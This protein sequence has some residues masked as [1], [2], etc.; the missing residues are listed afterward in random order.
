MSTSS[1][2]SEPF[3]EERFLEDLQ[4]GSEELGSPY[5]EKAVKEFVKAHDGLMRN[6]AMQ[7]RGSS[8]PGMPIIF[9][10]ILVDSPATATEMAISN[11]WLRPDDPMVVLAKACGTQFKESFEQGE[12]T[13]NTGCHGMLLYLGGLQPLDELL[14][15]PGMPE[16]IKAHRK[17]FVDLGL[18]QCLIAH[19]HYFERLV[20]IYFF[21]QGP[22]SKEALDKVVAMAGVPPPSDAKYRDIIGVLLD[23]PYYLTVVMDFNTGKVVWVEYHMLFP[24]K[25]PPNM[26]IP[27]VGEQMTK[28]WDMPSYEYEVME[29]LSYCFGD[30]RR[31]EVLG[32][33]SYCGG[34]RSLMQQYGIVGA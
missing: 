24:I 4:K 14:A 28:F 8:D 11:G 20:S 21:A 23:S 3:S 31:G 34:F 1:M 32:L 10:V 27:D 12:Y 25:L 22:L 33:R 13:A 18:T 5:D 9:R 16:G 26:E 15:T 19:F 30:T 17:E 29:M 7:L 2:D 6:A